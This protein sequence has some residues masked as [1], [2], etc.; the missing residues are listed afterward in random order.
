VERTGRGQALQPPLLG[1]RTEYERYDDQVASAVEKI[2]CVSYPSPSAGLR[3]LDP[4]PGRLAPL[5]A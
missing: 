2:A 1:S 3:F 4:D 5:P